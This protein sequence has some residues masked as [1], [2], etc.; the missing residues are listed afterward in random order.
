MNLFYLNFLCSV[1]MF[2]KC[3]TVHNRFTC[4]VNFFTLKFEGEFVQKYSVSKV[5]KVYKYMIVYNT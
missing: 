5:Q 1:L 3:S 4:I 2:F